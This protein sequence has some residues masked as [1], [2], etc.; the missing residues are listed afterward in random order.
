MTYEIGFVGTGRMA[1]AMIQGI[2]AKGLHTPD[3]IV[4][5]SPSPASRERI[6]RDLGIHTCNNLAE[7]AGLTDF[8]VLAMKPHQLGEVFAEQPYEIGP[9]HIV[10]SVL[11]GVRIETLKSYVPEAKIFRIMPN[12]PS[13]V[14]E[15]VS[16]FSRNEGVSD[17]DARRLERVLDSF[18]LAVEIPEDQMDAV[19]GLSGGSPAF[20]FMV[21]GAMAR[22]GR[23]LG[24]QADVSIKLSAQS[25]LGAAKMVLET[26]LDPKALKE[27]VCTPKGTTAEGVKVLE[28][29]RVEE[30]FVEAVKASARRSAELG[31]E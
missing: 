16:C 26:G 23:E 11:A 3:E 7:I 24:L 31:G 20:V 1:T 15:G 4:A 28:D 6:E 13:A 27:A 25:V 29:Y 9:M 10:A 14:L 5:C 18:G 17:I 2:L 19:A 21:I 8:I 30:A 22:A 12:L